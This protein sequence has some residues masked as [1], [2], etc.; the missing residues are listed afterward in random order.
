MVTE[1]QEG[2]QKQDWKR[3]SKIVWVLLGQNN[4]Y[5]WNLEET[6]RGLYP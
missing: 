2:V 5:P 3:K 6:Q 1:G 4:I